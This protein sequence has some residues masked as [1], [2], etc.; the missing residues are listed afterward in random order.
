MKYQYDKSGIYSVFYG[1]L[2]LIRNLIIDSVRRIKCLVDYFVMVLNLST[3]NLIFLCFDVIYG[4]N[5]GV[6]YIRFFD[7]VVSGCY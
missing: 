7:M 6:G 4:V 3:H 2:Q 5:Y 1:V